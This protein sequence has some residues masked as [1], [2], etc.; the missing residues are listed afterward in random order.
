M[1][2]MVDPKAQHQAIK[3]RIDDRIKDIFESGAFILGPN[4][5]ELER[6]VAAYHEVPY[7][8][9]L[10]SGTDALHLALRAAGVSK[11]DEVITTPFSFFATVEAIIYCGAK[12]VLVD[13]DPDTFN[14]N[15]SAV[16]EQ[17]NKR[18]KA[19]LPV[20]IFGHPVDMEALMSVADNQDGKELKVVEDCA[21]AFG[22]D[23]QGKRVG[24]FGVAG[25]YSFYPSKNFSCYGDGGMVVTS[26]SEINDRIRRLRNHGSSR[27]Y[28]HDEV[29]Y[30]SRLD[31]MQAAVL[32]VKLK[33]IDHYNDLRRF[34]AESYRER[35]ADLPLILPVERKGCR[36]VYHQFTLRSDRRDE[37]SAYLQG[38][39]IST[40]VY[41]PA[42]IHLQKALDEFNWSKGDFLEAEKASR[43]V[44]SIPMYPELPASDVDFIC[45]KIRSFFSR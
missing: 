17:I 45:D 3:D 27:T 40:V 5:M 35:L 43:E 36:H 16:E 11:G 1:I 42:P 33:R 8:I 26:I 41:Y 14:M 30:N 19:I 13:I 6:K 21:Q 29:G 2:P 25:C 24:S 7:A 12:P 34:V 9:G 15:I 4:V 31:E 20:H 38:E 10:A 23:V 32:N 37:L 44:L 22:A 28:Q 18:T 39:G